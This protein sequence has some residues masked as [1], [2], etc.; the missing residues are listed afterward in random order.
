MNACVTSNDATYV[1][2]FGI[3]AMPNAGTHPDSQADRESVG[4]IRKS[5]LQRLVSYTGS[6]KSMVFYAGI[7]PAAAILNVSI[8]T[9]ASLLA[10]MVVVSLIWHELAALAL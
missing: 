3:P 5:L 9:Y 1:E 2:W 6:P 4:D 7:F 10:M 8:T